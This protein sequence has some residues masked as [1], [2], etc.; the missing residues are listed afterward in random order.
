MVDAVAP[1]CGG[2]SNLEEKDDNFCTS[3]G[4]KTSKVLFKVREN[5]V[6]IKSMKERQ[7]ILLLG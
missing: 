1:V 3:C 2:C 4:L 5:K 6:N 7:L